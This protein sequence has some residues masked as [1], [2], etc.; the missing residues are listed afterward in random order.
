VD[1]QRPGNLRTVAVTLEAACQKVVSPEMEFQ[2]AL[3]VDGEHFTLTA[4]GGTVTVRYSAA[5][6]PDVSVTTEYEP[7]VAAADGR[8]TMNDFTA[9]HMQVVTHTPDKDAE[10]LKL[11]G[12]AMARTV[13][14]D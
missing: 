14:Q 1:L 9:N 6:A 2:A 8:M 5:E 12:R 13:D 10:L 11:L 7:M 3:D 4:R